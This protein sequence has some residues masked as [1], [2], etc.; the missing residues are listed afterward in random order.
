MIKL[1]EFGYESKLDDPSTMF[2]YTWQTKSFINGEKQSE[3][4]NRLADY[5]GSESAAGTSS[6]TTALMMSLLAVGVR[7]GDEVIT[8]PFTWISSVEV[9]AQ[10]GAKPVFVDINQD[11]MCID[12]REVGKKITKKTKAVICVDL[13]GN[14]CDIDTLRSYDLPI[15][16]DAAQ[17]IG[18]KYKGQRIGKQ[19]DLTCFSFYPTKNLSCWGDAG[20]VSGKKELIDEIKL[21]R[22][23]AQH[24]KFNTVKVGYNARMDTIQAEILCNKFPHLDLWNN[25]RKEIAG[26]YN[27]MLENIVKTPTSR[28]YSDSVWHQYVIRSKNNKKIQQALSEKQIQSRVYY[29]IPLHK[30]RPYSDGMS[31]KN[32]E[33]CSDTGLAIPVHQYLSDSEI[34]MI[35]ETVKQ[36]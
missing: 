3:L 36:A 22:N 7:P 24:K 20:A 2:A 19:A 23:H 12:V 33:E 10:L 27:S 4:E 5:C 34:E 26:Y 21:L 31:Y 15:I 28:N 30:T 11:D 32:A 8:T 6:C 16:E 13:F 25:R 1:S 17:S 9:I 18:A 14:V 29:E 35:A